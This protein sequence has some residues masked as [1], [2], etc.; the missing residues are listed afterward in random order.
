[1]C[2]GI[3]YYTFIFIWSGLVGWLVVVCCCLDF[4]L[5]T[6]HFHN[7]VLIA[8]FL[9]VL[10]DLKQYR[11][12]VSEWLRRLIR[13]QLGFA[14]AGSSPVHVVLPNLTPFLRLFDP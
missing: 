6:A 14:C 8:K 12:M 9:L 10:V 4:L 11:D 1:M 3:N 7:R 13:N 2:G 5:L